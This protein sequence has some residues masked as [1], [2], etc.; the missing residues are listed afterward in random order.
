MDLQRDL[1]TDFQ[2]DSD[3]REFLASYAVASAAAGE[4]ATELFADVFLAAGPDGA[5]PVP[6]SVLS[7]AIS[8]RRKML[9][10][11]GCRGTRLAWAEQAAL[12]GRY[13]LLKT[14]W[15]LAFD[16]RE[17]IRLRSTLIL[18][19]QKDG[20][21]AVFYLSHEELTTVLREHGMVL[22]D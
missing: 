9:E 2:M 3:V 6:R 1:Q 21:R 17:D 16:Q 10:G 22:R 13:V 11:L 7:V 5:K 18:L 12:D 15:L 19:R 4:E 20:L 14:E 8:Q